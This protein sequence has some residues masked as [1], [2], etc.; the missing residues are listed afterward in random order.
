M[1]N[2]LGDSFMSVLDKFQLEGQVAIITGGGRG[3]GKA[4]A[5][6][7]AEAGANVV[8]P[9]IQEDLA[10]ETAGELEQLGVQTIGIDIDVTS[11]DQVKQMVETTIE[12]MGRIDILMNNAGITKLKAAEK[13]SKEEFQGI[14]DVNLTGAFLCSREVGKYMIDSGTPGKI[15]NMSSMSSFIANYPQK[16]MA[17]N[18]SKAGVTMMTKALASEWVGHGIRVNEIAPGYMAT[19]MTKDF[20][21]EDPERAQRYYIEGTPMERPGEPEELAGVAVFLGS[22]A[23]SYMTGATVRVDGGYTIR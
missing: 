12:E 15:I 19:E 3:L 10:R 20:F 4:I 17:Y 5:R 1:I 22:E 8:I 9:D 16:Q 18:V 11:E 7:F 2:Q 14:I 6:G 23:S 13:L 21:E